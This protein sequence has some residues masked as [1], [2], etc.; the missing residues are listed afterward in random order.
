MKIGETVAIKG[1]ARE[2]SLVIPTTP[3]ALS[4]SKG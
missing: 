4:R 1:T 2:R 3:V